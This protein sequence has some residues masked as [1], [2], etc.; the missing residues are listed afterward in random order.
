MDINMTFCRY[1]DYGH[2][3]GSCWEHGNLMA[4]SGSTGH[5]H[6]QGLRWQQ[7]PFTSTWLSVTAWPTD[8]NMDSGGSTSHRYLHGLLVTQGVNINMAPGTA[9]P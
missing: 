9:K 1:T 4:L 2:P 7:R 6:P 8:S 3:Y 5:G